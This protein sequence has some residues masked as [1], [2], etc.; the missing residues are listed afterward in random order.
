VNRWRTEEIVG[1]TEDGRFRRIV[2]QEGRLRCGTLSFAPGDYVE[3]HAHL[4]SD[5][6]FYGIAGSGRIT[7]EGESLDIGP[8]D[9]VFIPAGERHMVEVSESAQEPFVIFAAVTPNTGDDTVFSSAN[10]T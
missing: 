1:T 2:V 4:T 6:V 9:L 8:G 7:V 3:E 5:E 10:E